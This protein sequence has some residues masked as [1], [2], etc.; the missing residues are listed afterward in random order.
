M[1][2]AE[3]DNS[4]LSCLRKVIVDSGI[5]KYLQPVV[6]SKRIGGHT[7]SWTK[8]HKIN[9][10]GLAANLEKIGKKHWDS[11]LA[12]AT[13]RVP[14]G[15]DGVVGKMVAVFGY[16]FTGGRPGVIVGYLFRLD[17]LVDRCG[18]QTASAA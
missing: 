18:L 12:C 2:L 16:N 5:L 10:H 14:D 17:E 9:Y 3:I 13:V 11:F 1:P 15:H 4:Q 7:K 6:R 8:R